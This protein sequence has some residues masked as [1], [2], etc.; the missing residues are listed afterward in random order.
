[1]NENFKDIEEY[2]LALAKTKQSGD[3]KVG[4]LGKITSVGVGGA[5]GAGAA[6][7]AASAVGAS[8]LLGS[9]TLGALLGGIFVTTTPVGWIVGGVAAGALLGNGVS[10]L[11][12]N[13]A[14]NDE[15]KRRNINELTER[16][17]LVRKNK[18]RKGI[19]TLLP[20]ISLKLKNL[21]DENFIEKEKAI[22][23]M[24]GIESGALNPEY[25]IEFLDE[26]FAA[27]K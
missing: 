18:A 11:I 23:L 3:D 1:M 13:G 26:S 12:S 9:S 5:A 27:K 4:K 20:A 6:V 19:N 7:A 10:K 2:K 24:N 25:V 14:K 16:I 22:E 15:I 8:T 17:E 21:I